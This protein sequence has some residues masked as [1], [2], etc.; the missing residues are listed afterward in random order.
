[1]V[2]KTIQIRHLISKNTILFV[3]VICDTVSVDMKLQKNVIYKIQSHY[4]RPVEKGTRRKQ[5]IFESLGPSDPVASRRLLKKTRSSATKNKVG[6]SLQSRRLL[7]TKSRRN[8][9]SRRLIFR[10]LFETILFGIFV[11]YHPFIPE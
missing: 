2:N 7:F 10:K 6:D 9:K 5:N 11:L 3:C 4:K 1:M 8:Y